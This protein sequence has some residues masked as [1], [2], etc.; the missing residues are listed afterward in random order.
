MSKNMLI[1]RDDKIIDKSFESKK[2]GQNYALIIALVAIIGD[3]ICILFD[4]EIV[5]GVVSGVGLTGLVSE[6]LGRSK[7]SSK[8]RPHD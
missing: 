1:T 7:S 5:G 6:F 8:N 4:H 3:I 2:R